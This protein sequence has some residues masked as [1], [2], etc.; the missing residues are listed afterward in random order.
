V[1]N[2]TSPFFRP[3][4]LLAVIRQSVMHDQRDARS[5]TIFHATKPT[6]SWLVLIF[7]PTE[8]RRLSW[9]EW[10]VTH[11]HC[12]CAYSMWS[13]FVAVS[14]TLTTT[15][16]L[17]WSLDFYCIYR[18]GRKVAVY[19]FMVYAEINACTKVITG[20]PVCVCVTWQLSH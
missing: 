14:I 7:H 18:H 5:M 19:V 17:L 4:M 2:C 16:I 6:A 20:V 3:L 13:N 11:Q 15:N 12:I 8:G 1:L 10:L 9:F